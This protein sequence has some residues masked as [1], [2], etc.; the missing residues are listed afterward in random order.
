[1]FWNTPMNDNL[2]PASSR[3]VT[4]RVEKLEVLVVQFGI[5]HGYSA[6]P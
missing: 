2:F 4:R 3:V 6:Y 1:M 5:G